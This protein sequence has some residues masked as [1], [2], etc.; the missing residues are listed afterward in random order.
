MKLA[1]AVAASLLI[2]APASAQQPPKSPA[3]KSQK[4]GKK[5]PRLNPVAASYAAMTLN[6]RIAIQSDLIWTADYNGTATGEFGER[7]IAAVKAFQKQNGGKETGVLNPQERTALAAAAKSRREAVGWRIIDDAPSGVRLGLPGKLVPQSAH[8]KAG[9]RWSSARG[10]VQVETFR[11]RGTSDLA[12]VFAQQKK[13]P[14][15]RKASYSVLRSDFFVVAGLQGLKKVY[16]RAHLRDDEVRGV[17]I[18]YDQALE[19]T[20]DAVAV[21]MSSA[22]VPFPAAEAAAPSRPKVEYGT[23]LV[24]SEAGHVLAHRRTAEDCHVLTVAGIGGADRIADDKASDLALLRVYGAPARKPAVLATDVVKAGDVTLAGIADPQAQ[25][26]GHAIST[27]RARLSAAVL[28]PAPAP[29]FAGAPAL[30]AQGRVLGVVSPHTAQAVL[31]PSPAVR[32]F[33]AAHGV[34]PAAS[35]DASLETAKGALVR[36]ICVRK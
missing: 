31:I 3:A 6:E 36:V 8:A 17:T 12:S 16:V 26:G 11:L 4:S 25:T 18:L 15:D 7:A 34:A 9:T 19:G 28:D 32:A 20:M 5:P 22:F 1:F 23:G 33:L 13:E 21:A 24:V 27:A 35:N 29:G 30:D 2:A 10:E 14:G